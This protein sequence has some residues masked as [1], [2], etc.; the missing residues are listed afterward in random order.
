MLDGQFGT[1]QEA[2]GGPFQC[3]L[4][5]PNTVSIVLSAFIL[6]GFPR[7]AEQAKAL[8]ALLAEIGQAPDSAVNF[9]VPD[10]VLVQRLLGRGR[11][12]DNEATI[13]RR[14]EV[15]REKTAPVIAF[16][17]KQGTLVSVDGNQEMDAVTEALKACISA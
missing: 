15:Y 7:N 11:K 2:E 14:L 8:D 16:Y 1:Q 4:V 5:R 6:D 12:D 13:A 9:D 10:E 3:L 17:E